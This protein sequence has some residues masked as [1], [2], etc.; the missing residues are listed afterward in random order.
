MIFKYTIAWKKYIYGQT[1]VIPTA[2]AIIPLER[3]RT[4]TNVI[5]LVLCHE[6]G[7]C[8]RVLILHQIDML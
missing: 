4:R 2:A 8:L 3:W 6:T 1:N 7:W 5:E